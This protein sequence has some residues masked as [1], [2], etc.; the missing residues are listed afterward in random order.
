MRKYEKLFLI[1][2]HRKCVFAANDINSTIPVR[3]K[4][5]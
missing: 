4:N 2:H 5:N 1:H 3:I